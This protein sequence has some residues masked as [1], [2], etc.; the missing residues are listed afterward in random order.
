MS[1]LE[2]LTGKKFGRWLI[3]SRADNSKSGDT[4]WNCICQCEAKT[5]RVVSA[6]NLKRGKSKS[7][8]CYNHEQLMARNTKHGLAHSRLYRIWCNM[9][10][11]CLN[12]NILCYDRYGKKGITVCKEWV[13]S[14]DNFKKW[15]LENG[16]NERLTIDRINPNG[17]YEPDN[18]RWADY[19]EQA[20]NKNNNFNIEYKGTC[21]SLEQWSR[22]VNIHSKTIKNRLIAGWTV[23]QALGYEAPLVIQ[24]QQRYKIEI[25][26]EI[27][28]IKG[29]SE[30][31]NLK[32]STVKGRIRNGWTIE[33]ALGLT[34][35][36]KT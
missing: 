24:T 19:T 27:Y 15:S 18:C 14:F 22:E 7:C 11:R 13:E 2:D 34:P 17:N 1:K 31:L 26:G 25:D 3:I 10:S 35:R 21:K 8:G 4:M 29:A 5:K 30:K 28:N 12:E 16:Y 6:T 20:N 23:A 32:Y 33:E 9:K 36:K